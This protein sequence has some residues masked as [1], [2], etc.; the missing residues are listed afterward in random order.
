MEAILSPQR[1]IGLILDKGDLIS[2]VTPDKIEVRTSSAIA[3]FS[4]LRDAEDAIFFED[5]S[6]EEAQKK[7]CGEVIF[8]Q[9]FRLFLPLFD[10]TLSSALRREAACELEAMLSVWAFLPNWLGERFY[11]TPFPRPERLDEAI[12]L[13]SFSFA[14]RLRG[15]LLTLRKRQP[16]IREMWAAWNQIPDHYFPQDM[17]RDKV[18]Q[19][20][21]SN[22]LFLR[23][24]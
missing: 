4:W 6:A 20:F 9:A 19:I 17:P 22:G 11:T 24:V 21:A 12:D 1:G 15:F 16:L 14:K 5:I 2:V 23:F 8:E 3:V 18:W 10:S 7:L 13:V